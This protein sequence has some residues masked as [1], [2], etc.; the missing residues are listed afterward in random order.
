MFLDDRFFLFPDLLM[1]GHFFR[2][3][4][5][6]LLEMYFFS[7]ESQGLMPSFIVVHLNVFSSLR[8]SSCLPDPRDPYF[9]SSLI[10]RSSYWHSQMFCAWVA[11]R[12]RVSSHMGESHI[13]AP[14]EMRVPHGTQRW[15][16][17][18]QLNCYVY[19][20]LTLL[21]LLF[22]MFIYLVSVHII[23]HYLMYSIF[24]Y[25]MYGIRLNSALSEVYPHSL[26]Y[27][28]YTQI[29]KYLYKFCII[30]WFCPHT[31]G[32]Y[33]KLPQTPTKKE[34]PS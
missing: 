29:S 10:T 6:T 25:G 21:Y 17:G 11:D 30:Q 19:V 8:G 18:G 24:M 23:S 1:Q 32:R 5:R 14:G 13:K 12:L 33:P 3:L 34:I 7:R 22:I 28:I 16:F 20:I 15:F 27:T 31:L 9:R 26:T 2:V 4:G